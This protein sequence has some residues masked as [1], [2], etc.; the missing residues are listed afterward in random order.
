MLDL[1]AG[2]KVCRQRLWQDCIKRR[3]EL[4]TLL[5]SGIPKGAAR[6]GLTYGIPQVNHAVNSNLRLMQSALRGLR[7][8]FLRLYTGLNSENVLAWSSSGYINA[9]LSRFF[10]NLGF[11]QLIINIHRQTKFYIS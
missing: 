9:R 5:T 6:E 1:T 7:Q 11:V 4:T 2:Q 10:D 3:F 8:L